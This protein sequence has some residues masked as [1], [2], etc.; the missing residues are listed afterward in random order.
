MEY[1]SNA[2]EPKPKKYSLED[3]FGL[4]VL[5]TGESITQSL[6]SQIDHD[7]AGNV[8]KIPTPLKDFATYW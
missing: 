2:D 8:K 6:T 4:D 3:L 5:M 7:M 1:D